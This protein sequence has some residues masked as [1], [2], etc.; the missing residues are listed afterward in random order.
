LARSGR[1][2]RVRMPPSRFPDVPVQARLL[3]RLVARPVPTSGSARPAVRL[4]PV[5]AHG[6]VG[7]TPLLRP[8]THVDPRDPSRHAGVFVAAVC[9][10]VAGALGRAERSQCRGAETELT[11]LLRLA[12]NSP[13]T[14]RQL[15]VNSAARVQSAGRAAGATPV[16]DSYDRSAK[17]RE[18]LRCKGYRGAGNSASTLGQLCVNSWS[19]LRQLS[20][21]TFSGVNRGDPKTSG[22]ASARG[23]PRRWIVR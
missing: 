17:P 16:T 23:R 18:A 2:I 5:A 15:L 22:C 19:T 3:G 4:N 12:G 21:A 10:S 9:G 1:A 6:S 14:L 11:W 20:D 13:A 7:I 8:H